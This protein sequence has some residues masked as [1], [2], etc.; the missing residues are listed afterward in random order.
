[1][2]I[3]TPNR[4]GV[5]RR[6]RLAL[7]AA[8]LGLA[9]IA[10]CGGGSSDDGQ[11]QGPVLDTP[12]V[13][14]VTP[15]KGKPVGGSFVT[16]R[17]SGFLEEV[18]GANTVL[19]GDA[20]ATSVVTVDDAT[21]TCRT[22]QGDSLA[23][24]DVTVRNSRGEGV[25]PAAFTYI[26][27]AN[28]VTDLNGDGLSDIV[29]SAPLQAT[30]GIHEGSVHVFYGRDEAAPM[31]DTLATGAD[32][33]LTGMVTGE[34][35]G[36]SS[37]TGDVDGDG[38]D[39]LIVGACDTDGTTQDRGAV[40]VFFGPLPASG[41]MTSAQADVVL[42]GED[43]HDRDFFGH[44]LS[45]GDVDGDG[46]DDILVGA[47]GVD[48]APDTADEQV[49]VGAVYLFTGGA[50]LASK[51]ALQAD[52]V[53]RG[54]AVGDGLGNT[55]CLADLTGDGRSEM[56][57]GASRANPSYDSLGRPDAGSVFVFTGDQ[58]GAE[59]RSSEAAAAFHGAVKGDRFGEALAA[60]DVDGD[61]EMDLLVAAPASET[62]GNMTGRVYVFSGA[63]SLAGRVAA[64]ADVVLSGTE[65][66]ADF[67]RD[68]T[69]ADLDSDG[70]SDIMV[71]A[72]QSS[73]TAVMSGRCYVF[74][75]GA[76]L[77]DTPSYAADIV[78][79][80]EPLPS[81]RF[82]LCVEVIDVDLDGFADIMSGAV[83]NDTGGVNA[84]QVNIFCGNDS[85]L[86]R[87]ASGDDLTL[88]GV[89]YGSAFGHSM[90]RGQ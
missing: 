77:S 85:P 19:F 20:E 55:C 64:E 84:G 79:T 17:G 58:L 37:A 51:T 90:C 34:R 69:C 33:S 14:L 46:R 83:G 29:V 49:D 8:A 6:T 36:I 56:L 12:V 48:F 88:T 13:A 71:G 80:G 62:T 1:M 22:P 32:V 44:A 70:V 24:V 82:G 41:L 61:G 5:A 63:G 68:L 31:G 35:F 11:G 52:F 15:D 45:V 76:D 30:A 72:P 87:G 7:P 40:Y 75:G 60:G 81:E 65:S 78:F 27:T 26:A 9:L 50:S 66:Q 10:S 21:I 54:V 3:S 74:M 28:I 67:G 16:I 73:V 39:D 42:T 23:V 89:V 59:V 43:V 2:K 38:Q 18:V 4:S 25:L 57:V 53:V 86:D 47:P